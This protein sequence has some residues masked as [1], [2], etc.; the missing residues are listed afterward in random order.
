MTFVMCLSEG[1]LTLVSDEVMTQ[2]RA[3]V[4]KLQDAPNATMP[5]WKRAQQESYSIG[6]DDGQ[7]QAGNDLEVLLDDLSGVE[8]RPDA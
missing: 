7:I 6:F 2:L 1:G 8:R 3:L 5:A 4:A